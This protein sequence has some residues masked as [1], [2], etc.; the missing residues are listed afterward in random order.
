ML[1][2]EGTGWTCSVNSHNMYMGQ[3]KQVRKKKKYTKEEIKGTNIHKYHF[4]GFF[5]RNAFPRSNI[6]IFTETAQNI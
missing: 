4:L 6:F 2:K 3:N 5:L 1:G